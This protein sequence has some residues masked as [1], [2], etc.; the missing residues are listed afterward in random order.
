LAV[1]IS[2]EHNKVLD[3]DPGS[4]KH[5]RHCD[6]T[7][8]AEDVWPV[9][10]GRLVTENRRFSFCRSPVFLMIRLTDSAL[11]SEVLILFGGTCF[12]I[13]VEET[14]TVVTLESVRV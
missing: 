1:P 10:S 4:E 11:F 3:P 7:A 8:Q 2:S 9:S 13:Q 5:N 14:A 6:N 12:E